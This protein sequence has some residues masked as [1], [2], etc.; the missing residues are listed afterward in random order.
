MRRG[1]SRYAVV[2]LAATAAHYALLTALVEWAQWSAWLASGLGAALGAQ[3][4]FLG[5]RRFTFA[6]RGPWWPAWVKFQGTAV[7]GAA[8]GMALVAAGVAVGLHYL[9]AQAVATGVGLLVTYAINRVWTFA[10]PAPASPPP[11]P[12]RH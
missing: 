9:L 1:L 10:K 5:N 2:G 4:A 6:H 11:H 8:L 7:L 3:V 12:G